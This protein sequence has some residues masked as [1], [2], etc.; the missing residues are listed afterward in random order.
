MEIKNFE[1]NR[2]AKIFQVPLQLFPGLDGFVYLL[3]VESIEWGSYRVL[4]DTGS[5][6]GE[7]NQQIAAATSVAVPARASGTSRC[8]AWR[9]SHCV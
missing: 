4:I 8:W 2:G 9:S 5:G 7:S 1:S 3:F 6:F